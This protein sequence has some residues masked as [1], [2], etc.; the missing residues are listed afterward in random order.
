MNEKL[1]VFLFANIEKKGN[2]LKIEYTLSNRLDCEIFIFNQLFQ[3]D[4][5]G[6]QTLDPNICY[7]ILDDETICISKQ[8]MKIPEELKAEAPEIPYLTRISPM[9]IFKESINLTLPLHINTPYIESYFKHKKITKEKIKFIIGY[10]I[11]S[12]SEI[13][14]IKE[15]KIKNETV[16]LMKSYGIGVMHQKFVESKPFMMSIPI[17]LPK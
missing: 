5:K 3:T 11:P 1:N 12:E 9:E 2:E 15:A 10:I 7:T 13:I 16:F 14:R 17:L 6:N 8:L 4:M